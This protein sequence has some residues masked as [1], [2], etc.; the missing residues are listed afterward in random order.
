[1]YDI[2]NVLIALKIISKVNYMFGTKKIPLFVYS[3]PPPSG[4]LIPVTVFFQTL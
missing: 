2:A 4:L 3:G 1:M